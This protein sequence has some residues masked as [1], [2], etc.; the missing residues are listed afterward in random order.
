M[1]GFMPLNSANLVDKALTYKGQNLIDNPSNLKNGRVYLF[2]G[3][4]D[5]TVKNSLLNLSHVFGL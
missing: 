4:K 2:G 1:S 5:T 3:T